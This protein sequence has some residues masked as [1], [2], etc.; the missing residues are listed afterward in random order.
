MLSIRF[1]TEGLLSNHYG[2]LMEQSLDNFDAAP[3][4]VTLSVSTICSEILSQIALVVCLRKKF[5]IWVDRLNIFPL[6]L[7]DGVKAPDAEILKQL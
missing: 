6:G 1:A 3:F 7:P 4:L 2:D 5:T